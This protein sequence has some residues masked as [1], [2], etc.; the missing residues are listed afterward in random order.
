[1][2][3]KDFWM[4]IGTASATISGFALIVFAIYYSPIQSIRREASQLGLKGPI[5]NIVLMGI[6]VGFVLTLI[7]L[8]MAVISL[9]SYT[10]QYLE[11][12]NMESLA[13]LSFTI[14]IVL[15]LMILLYFDRHNAHFVC[16]NR[17]IEI[18]NHAV[19]KLEAE[20]SSL[21]RIFAISKIWLNENIDSINSLTNEDK[22]T[23]IKRVDEYYRRKQIVETCEANCIESFKSF[24]ERK[25]ISYGNLRK[26]WS[27][28]DDL[29]LDIENI[30]GEIETDIKGMIA[31]F[32]E[33]FDL[34]KLA[35]EY[36]NLFDR[37]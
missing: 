27:Q 26:L 2:P 33:T 23:Y 4:L 31:R 13:I 1:M 28:H 12:R 10:A 19:R 17:F 37:K 7:P 36:P 5:T 16:G 15:I 32:P 8:V 18:R 3:N 21:K 14:G 6:L 35:K 22:K 20:L 29:K 9:T 30:R 34:S 11:L 24:E 25:I